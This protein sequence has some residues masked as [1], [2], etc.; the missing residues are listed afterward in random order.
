MQTKYQDKF[1]HPMPRTVGK[2]R[3]HMVDSG[4]HSSF[5]FLR[6]GNQQRQWRLRCVTE[7]RLPRIHQS[8]E[9]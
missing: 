5:T 7:G 2:V 9:R 4:L 6:H 1:G 3:P 8:L